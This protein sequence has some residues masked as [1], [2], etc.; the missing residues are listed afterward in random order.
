V[1]ERQRATFGATPVSPGAAVDVGALAS[2]VSSGGAMLDDL[3]GLLADPLEGVEALFTGC[4]FIKNREW[5]KRDR[6]AGPSGTPASTPSGASTRIRQQK[7]TARPNVVPR[8]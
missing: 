4:V 3:A 1:G 6:F 5:N 2:I 8:A 7:L